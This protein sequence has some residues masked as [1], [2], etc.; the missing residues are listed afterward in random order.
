MKRTDDKITLVNIEFNLNTCKNLLKKERDALSYTTTNF[1][2]F[3]QAFG[4]NL[5]LRDFVNIWM[6]ED[7]VQDLDSVTWGIFQ[8]CFYDNLFN[9]DQ[10]SKIQDKKLLN[11][12]TTNCLLLVIRKKMKK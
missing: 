3:F 7:R 2:H 1:F 5:K 10:N 4:I 12:K 6:V 8:I 9:P 11:K